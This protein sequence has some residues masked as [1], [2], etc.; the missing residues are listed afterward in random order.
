MFYTALIILHTFGM[1][2]FLTF[3]IKTKANYF[4]LKKFL[5]LITILLFAAPE[6]S[7][8]QQPLWH[9]IG[10]DQ[11]L[12][13][14][15]VTAI[16]RIPGGKLFVGT[17]IGLYSYDGFTFRKVELSATGRINPYINCLAT[18]GKFLIVGARD[19]LILYNTENQH[20]E[21][22]NNP[23][24]CIGGIADLYHN[25]EKTRIYARTH[26]GILTI[27]ISN[28][29]L[30]VIDVL[31]NPDPRRLRIVSDQEIHG[32]VLRKKFVSVKNH[33]QTDL[34]ADPGMLDAWW[35]EK[36]N[37]W[38]IVKEDGI[39]LLD[40][41]YRNL[42][43]LPYNIEIRTNENNWIYPDQQGGCW[44]QSSGKFAFIGSASDK[45][46]EFYSNEAGNLYSFTSNTAQAFFTE[47]D[48]TRWV[49]GD[50][51]GLAYLSPACSKIRFLTNEQAG[52]QH[53]WCFRYEN[54]TGK[55]LCGTTS[56]I[57][58][59]MLVNGEF[60]HR[61]LYYPPGFNR[62]SVNSIVELNAEEY[63]ISVYRE[64]FWTYN[65]ET[66]KFRP[67]SAVKNTIGTGFVFGISECS[68]GKVI[69]CTQFSAFLLDKKTLSTTPFTQP[70]FH[71]Y[72]IY[73]A[74]RDSRDR[75]LIA[76]GFGLQIFDSGLK[77]TAYYTTGSKTTGDLP[78][79]VIFCI[80]EMSPENY[81][82]ATMGG[83]LCRFNASDTTFL[84]VKLTTDPNNVFG[85]MPAGYNNYILTTSG[86]LCRVNI[87]NGKSV[88]LN[89]TNLLP[90]ND[91]NQQAYARYPEYIF[92]G[93]EKGMLI[94]NTKDLDRIFSASPEVIIRKNE[95]R[96][97]SLKLEPDEHALH[98]N[99]SFDKILPGSMCRFRYR[100]AGIDHTWQML[101][102]HQNTLI[103]NYLPPG[104]Y[105]LEVELF[106]ETGL[107]KAP[108]R[109]VPLA[110]LPHFYQTWWFR[111]MLLLVLTGTMFL[112]VRYFSLL[113]LRWKLQR[114]D[115]ERKIMLERSRI[116]RELHDNLGSQLT[117][118]ISGLETTGLL[119]K[120][121][122]L[123][124]T[125]V[126][127]DK[128][129]SAA[130]ESMQQLRDSIWALNPG[131]MTLQSLFIQYE[132]WVSRIT[133]PYESLQ[134]TF[135]AD[136]IPD[137]PIDPLNGLNLFRIM[138]EAVHNT[139]KHA[140][141]TKLITSVKTGSG[142]VSIQINDN[143]KG[144]IPGN[145]EGNGLSSMHQRAEVLKARLTIETS[146][147]SGTTVFIEIDKNTL[148]G[149]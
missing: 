126:N 8:A 55:L 109:S 131:S 96:V 93:G 36:E 5:C 110:V 67:L 130:R 113:R 32:F 27:D 12:P 116:S 74:V 49:G 82:I 15:N 137:I 57:L 56:G 136:N 99:L 1:Q 31:R 44:I 60:L 22:L 134:C 133:E 48:G 58:E 69:L 145:T 42:K 120:R 53:F 37:A 95:T 125:S 140:Q 26:C 79:N 33:R 103:Y 23:M 104:N 9:S 51:T 77:Q 149:V 119:L 148:T 2:V 112:V 78:S 70:G 46:P 54:E 144:F 16:T 129:Q 19:A 43:K 102:A 7:S 68:P 146:Q 143:G 65:K 62:F 89:K 28:G 94:L 59:G 25:P 39:Y 138:Q 92:A 47:P 90:F 118:L 40:S 63:L 84:P 11:G 76:G 38:L 123:E 6:K 64:G 18:D 45:S 71:N 142:T 29:K 114:L 13:D 61:R 30:T 124:K 85:I 3:G 135:L 20:T 35:W 139:L 115:A 108:G 117:Y 147:N 106:D 141:A 121:N 14:P 107:Y 10:I 98:L 111:F 86:G 122:K 75:Y 41:H 128:L 87:S 101:P 17:A 127:L 4:S 81:L 66:R 80:S 73:S 100:I 83:G 21:Q 132:K 97:E 88:M 91:F 34:Y 105:T 24:N 50:G 72:S 52:V